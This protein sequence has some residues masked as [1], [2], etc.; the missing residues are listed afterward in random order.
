MRWIVIWSVKHCCHKRCQM[1]IILSIIIPPG[2]LCLLHIVKHSIDFHYM[3]GC[4]VETHL[5]CIKCSDFYSLFC[6]FSLSLTVLQIIMNILA[7]PM[8]P[9]FSCSA[10][11]TMSVHRTW[12][13]RATSAVEIKQRMSF[14]V[15]VNA[16]INIYQ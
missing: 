1:D 14:K 15:C 3:I 12:E 13:A 4:T 2:M 6:I 7:L 16:S 11:V 10:L 5:Y 9:L 8:T